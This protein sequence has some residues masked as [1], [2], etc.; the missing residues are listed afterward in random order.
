MM[1]LMI[2]R[3][4][5]HVAALEDR[6]NCR[7]EVLRG[8]SLW[9]GP[10]GESRLPQLA[11]ARPPG[12][13]WVSLAPLIRGGAC[14][15]LGFRGPHADGFHRGRF[16]RTASLSRARLSSWPTL[17]LVT[18]RAFCAPAAVGVT[19]TTAGCTARARSQSVLRLGALP[20]PA[21]AA[22]AIAASTALVMRLPAPPRPTTTAGARREGAT[23]LAVHAQR[24]AL[25]S[26]S[27][28]GVAF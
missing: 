13:R 28:G 20:P 9:H 16:I 19:A 10:A 7:R 15:G 26:P 11:A 21:P 25:P 3:R 27:R 14:P 18:P 5:A 4:G 1:A 23:L 17:S 12:P 6:G 24:V 8:P 2:H 22:S